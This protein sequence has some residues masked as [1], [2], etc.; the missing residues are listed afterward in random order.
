MADPDA[1]VV[2]A[3]GFGAMTS[4]QRQLVRKLDSFLFGLEETKENLELELSAIRHRLELN[5]N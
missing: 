4:G 5:T 2:E 3:A 1:E